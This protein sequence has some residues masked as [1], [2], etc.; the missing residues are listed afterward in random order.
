ME[1][2]A[3]DAHNPSAKRP[4][5][6]WLVVDIPLMDYEA[7]LDLQHR[8]V[9]AKHGGRLPHEVILVLAHPPVFTFGRRGGEEHLLVDASFLKKK[10]IGTHRV[11]R[12]GY[13]T[14]HGPGQVVMYP[15][16]DLNRSGWRVVDFVSSLEE[17]GIRLAADWGIE[18]GR[19]PLNRGVWVA[20][21][22]LAYIGI[23]VRHWITFHGMAVN[24]DLSLEPFGWMNPCGLEGVRAT[25]LAEASGMRVSTR[26]A[27]KR[28]VNH[29]KT[30]LGITPVEATRSELESMI[31]A[32]A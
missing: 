3:S 23:A 9:H 22:K 5:H 11:E 24:V 30:Q 28:I 17:V 27:R 29:L 14:Y 26:E 16:V 20:N 31:G 21:R 32:T 13:V 19:N 7:A 15:I 8:I 6:G 25:S 4:D 1:M 2:T 12:G 18:A 10:G